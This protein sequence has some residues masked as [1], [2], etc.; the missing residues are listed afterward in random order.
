[1]VT[2]II[3][4]GEPVPTAVV[5][6]VIVLGVP[7]WCEGVY[8]LSGLPVEAAV[9]VVVGGRV[10]SGITI[11]IQFV[12]CASL[13]CTIKPA[14]ITCLSKSAYRLYSKNVKGVYIPGTRETGTKLEL[15]ICPTVQAVQM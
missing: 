15:E 4:F 7:G 6:V 13:L 1:M 2:V 14:I 8:I 10:G 12:P 11:I 3:L 9:G 5:A